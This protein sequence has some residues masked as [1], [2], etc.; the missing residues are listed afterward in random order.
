M[1]FEKIKKYS[2]V[3]IIST[4]KHGEYFHKYSGKLN[5][6]VAPIEP[7]LKNINETK[8]YDLDYFKNFEKNI[9]NL[10]ERFG[11]KRLETKIKIPL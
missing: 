6:N 11:S 7:I 2:V 9:E 3:K 4:K 10:M 1:V 8:E 5:H